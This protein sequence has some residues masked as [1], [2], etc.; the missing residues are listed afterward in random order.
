MRTSFMQRPSSSISARLLV[1][2]LSGLLGAIG[3]FWIGKS[4][5]VDGR[6]RLGNPVEAPAEAAPAPF[7]VRAEITRVSQG[8]LVRPG[9]TC[10]F[11]VQRT[12]HK[13]GSYE[14]NAQV[15]CGARLLYGGPGRGYFP[16]RITE[17]LRKDVVG[18]DPSTS[19]TDQDPA[20][21]IDTRLGVLSMWDDESGA[22]GAYR[23]EADILSF[24]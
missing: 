14:C 15:M 20:L 16:C 3:L 17:G 5:Y 18:I 8:E 24:Q 13:D 22:L 21:K 2:V 10:D 6:F 23:V 11:L 4:F 7:A 19:R 9:Q 12:V 1:L